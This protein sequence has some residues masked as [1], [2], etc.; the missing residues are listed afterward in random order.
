MQ[1]SRNISSDEP[2][3]LQCTILLIEDNRGDAVLT[4]IMLA[5][6]NDFKQTLLHVSRLDDGLS[7][8]KSSPVSVILADLS[9]PDSIGLE[10]FR[11]LHQ[12]APQIPIIVLTGNLDKKL[13]LTAIQEGAQDYLVKDEIN[14]LSLS[15]AI[16]YAIERKQAETHIRFQ[17][18]LLNQVRNAVF[19]T[20]ADGSIIFWNQPASQLYQWH[21]SEALGQAFNELLVPE[22]NQPLIKEIHAGLKR[23]LT[24]EGELTLKRKNGDTFPALLTFSAI[25][26]EAEQINGYIGVTNDISERVEVEKKLEHS[27]F[28]DTLTDLPNRALFSDRLSSA[29]ARGSREDGRYAV[30]VLDLDR[31]KVINDSLGHLVGDELLIQFSRR[32]ES[33]LRPGDTLARL[34]GDEFTILLENVPH[35]VD[36]IRV[37]ERI[38]EQMAQAFL[39]NGHEVYTSVSIGITFG[40]SNYQEPSDAIRDADIAMYRAKALGKGCH[41]I[42]ESGMHDRSLSQFKRENRVRLALE[43]NQFSV[44]FQP[45][46]DLQSGLCVG[47][48]A[49]LRWQASNS[50]E[51][52]TEEIISTAEETC[53]IIPIGQKVFEETGRQLKRWQTE[54]LLPEDFRIHINLTAKQLTHHGLVNQISQMLSRNKIS[55]HNI[56]LEL[57]ESVLMDHPT[58]TANLLK[59]LRKLDIHV[60]VGG[61]GTGYSSLKH[62]HLLPIDTIK[63][64]SYFIHDIDQNI[65]SSAIVQAIIG[66]GNNLGIQVIAEGVEHEQQRRLLTQLGCR[67]A[68]GFLF[69]SAL[70]PS[71][72]MHHLRKASN[73]AH[74]FH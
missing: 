64:S 23:N 71:V 45:I 35:T 74:P 28:H 18:S 52:S 38:H 49:L 27:A 6:A 16:Y 44:H 57:S 40:V 32:V 67:Y 39:L 19:A 15:K 11:K 2:R 29:I 42:Y 31:F 41:V 68:Q 37:A 47:C 22:C 53:L 50:S 4:E 65:T 8:L 7:L 69:N 62:L 46:V 55:G 70:E 58:L 54:S 66:L 61:F 51:L 21:A 3:D 48:E 30:L 5:E 59:T 43:N 36:A 63:I 12:H 10:T 9:L 73:S 26:N 34:G 25:R 13:A 60:C 1:E 33:C 17:A 56:T 14:A 20:A 72:M 24:W